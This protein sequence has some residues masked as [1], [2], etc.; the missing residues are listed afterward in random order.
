MGSFCHDGG[1]NGVIPKSTV[2]IYLELGIR[3]YLF[4]LLSFAPGIR[5]SIGPVICFGCGI[6]G[7]SILGVFVIV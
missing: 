5:T 3:I 2:I 1:A 6:I 7:V 4:D